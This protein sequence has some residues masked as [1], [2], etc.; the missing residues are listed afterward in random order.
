MAN[1]GSF[2]GVTLMSK[3]GWLRFHS[4]PRVETEPLFDHRSIYTLSGLGCFHVKLLGEK[5][6]NM[7]ERDLF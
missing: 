3:E 7:F 5:T 6:L 4:E 1:E 2:G